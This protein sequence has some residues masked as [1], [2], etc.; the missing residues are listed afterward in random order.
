MSG[1]KKNSRKKSPAEKILL[2]TVIIQLIQ[3]LVELIKKL[4]E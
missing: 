2:T 4:L 3:A 1:K